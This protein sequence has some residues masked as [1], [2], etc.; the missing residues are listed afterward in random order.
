MT[1]DN[2]DN[3]KFLYNK[4]TIEGT[5][6]KIT[7]LTLVVIIIVGAISTV[8]G[9]ERSMMVGDIELL[10]LDEFFPNP[11]IIGIAFILIKPHALDIE[12]NEPIFLAEKTQNNPDCYS[13]N[14]AKPVKV[15]YKTTYA[16]DFMNYIGM[17]ENTEV[18]GT[19]YHPIEEGLL[20]TLDQKEWKFAHDQ[21]ITDE[22][23]RWE[24]KQSQEPMS[25]EE[26][27][28]FDSNRDPEK[29]QEP[30]I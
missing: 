24:I 16:F 13:C 15:I 25:D 1:D 23:N 8:V 21:T 27:I 30:S 5:I 18:G 3:E 14:P 2:K 4:K 28:D 26:I 9:H 29:F 12:Q 6:I 22:L 7:M 20:L 17:I 10:D 19:V 11:Q